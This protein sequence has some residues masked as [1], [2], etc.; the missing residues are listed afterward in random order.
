MK[1]YDDLSI[2][3]VECT[4]NTS[5]VTIVDTG[6]DK[7]KYWTCSGS[8]KTSMEGSCTWDHVGKSKDLTFL[9]NIQDLK[10]TQ[11][12]TKDKL[13]LGCGENEFE[14][15][16]GKCIPKDAVRDGTIDCNTDVYGSDEWG[17]EGN[18]SMSLNKLSLNLVLLTEFV[19]V[20]QCC[21]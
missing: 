8:P 6:C 21:I 13:I 4:R 19:V 1:E 3:K 7:H 16:G 2:A 10:N 5:C 20:P 12:E 17:D 14:C 9:R 15:N 18:S 11:L